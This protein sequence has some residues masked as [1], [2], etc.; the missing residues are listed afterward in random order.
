MSKRPILIGITGGTGSGK[1]TVSKEICRRFD[2]ELIVMIEQD[3]YY[4]DQSHLSIEE[5]VKT[6]Y[7]HPNAFDTEL[8]VEHLKELSSWNKVEKPIYD[9][10]LHNRKNETE[11][12]EPTE[13]IIVEG[14]LVLE[15]KE[16]R[17]LLDIKIYVD[18][19][20]DVR[21]I[22]RLVR[23]IKERG[24]SL[25]SVINQY[26]NVVRPMHMQFIEPSKR[27]A[28]I[29]IPEGGHNKVAI[30]IIVGNIK[31]MVQKSE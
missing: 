2:K 4:K 19:D 28:D 6:N 29:I 27:Y 3:S 21:I 16:I 23:D 9:F 22:R 5:R 14:I 10:E 8:L 11:I 30:D 12:V 17:D 15:E 20:A 26:L 1:S 25:D 7:D 24:R 18:T 31:Q 13:I